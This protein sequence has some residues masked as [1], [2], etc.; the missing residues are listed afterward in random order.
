MLYEAFVLKVHHKLCTSS[1]KAAPT[2]GPQTN[3]GSNIKDSSWGTVLI[4]TTEATTQ[5]YNLEMSRT[6]GK[7]T[8]ICHIWPIKEISKHS[9]R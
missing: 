6:H 3:W 2:K 4:H 5:K 9:K 7:S 1:L 8:N